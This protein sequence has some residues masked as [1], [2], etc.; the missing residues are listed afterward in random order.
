MPKSEAEE[1]CNDYKALKIAPVLNQKLIS[2][3]LKFRINLKQK[4]KIP[5]LATSIKYDP[6]VWENMQIKSLKKYCSICTK[7]KYLL[8]D[9]IRTVRISLNFVPL[10]KKRLSGKC[11]S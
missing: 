1:L 9:E 10:K 6:Q 3:C 4:Q 8:R 11:S 2:N 5:S 7:I